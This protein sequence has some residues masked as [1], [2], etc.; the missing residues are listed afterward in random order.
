MITVTILTKNSALTL[1]ETLDSVKDFKEVLLWDTGSTDQTLEIAAT[2]P[3]TRVIS[4]S[5]QGFGKTHNLAS[6][7]ASYDW[8]LSLDS[9]EVLSPALAKEILK[10]PLDPTRVY[11]ILRRNY[12]NGKW[13]RWCG[14]WHPDWI[15]RLYNRQN[16]Q[17][18]DAAVHEKVITKGLQI[19]RLSH[20]MSHVPYREIGDFLSKMQLYSTLFAEERRGQKHAC[21][22]K[23]LLHSFSAFL[24][25]YLLK[26]GFLGGREGLIISLYNSHTTF[27]KYLKLS[28]NK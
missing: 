4:S 2:Y 22:S 17:F 10:L 19:H 12:F 28:E 16:T 18:T 7:A 14:G 8:I 21:L 1:K 26:R 5:F 3:N 15:C 6:S 27:Y 23:A 25:S 11:A 9:D 20:S 24:K 13:I